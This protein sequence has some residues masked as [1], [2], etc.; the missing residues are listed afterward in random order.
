MARLGLGAY[1]FSIAWP[2]VYPRG[3]GALNRPGLDF[4]DSLT[5]ALLEHAITPM[6][7]L[8]HWD[9][10]QGLQRRGGWPA[11][12]T[13][14]YFA[15]F[16]EQVARRLGD[17]ITL[18]IT[19]N[20]PQVAAHLGHEHG[21]HAPG[22]RGLGARSAGGPPPAAGARAG[23]R[24]AA[25]PGAAGAGGHRPEPGT[26]PP[27]RRQCRGRRRRQPRRRLLQPLVSRSAAARRLPRGP[28]GCLPGAGVAP[29]G[30]GRRR[31]GDRRAAGLPGRQLL[32]PLGGGGR[33]REPR[34]A[35]GRPAPAVLPA[36]RR[37]GARLRRP[38]GA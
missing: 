23:G 13:A 6:A 30:P 7:T 33:G 37:P 21:V 15:D 31:Q 27:R 1:R 2:R 10:P 12:D 17:R 4:Y 26:G 20:E 38:A 5:D 11:R 28:A 19:I 25:R 29:R 18:W 24:G 8:Y 3:Y 9:L 34:P 14:R 16:A 22:A 36:G 35:R 32:L